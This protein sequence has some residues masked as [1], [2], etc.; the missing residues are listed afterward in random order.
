MDYVKIGKYIKEK[1]V[2]KGLTQEELGKLVYVSGKAVSKWERGL[3]IPDINILEKLAHELDTD[4]YD[5][6]QIKKKSDIDVDKLVKEEL[7][8]NNKK[9]RKRIILVIIVI[10]ILFLIVLFKLLPFG[11]K[12]AKVKYTHNTDKI[13]SLAKPMF[14]FDYKYNENNYSYKNLRY[15]YILKS[16]I[17]NYINTLEHISCNNTVYYYDK[18]SNVTII[19]YDVKGNLLY[20]TVSYA[21]KDGNYCELLKLDEYTNKLGIMSVEVGLR[22]KP[23][24]WSVYFSPRVNPEDLSDYVATFYIEY[25]GK[26]LEFS[27]GTY[28]I[29]GN[30]LIYTRKSFREKS[31]IID[32]P[33]VSTFIIGEDKELILKENYLSDYRESIIVGGH[34]EANDK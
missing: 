29:I 25:K 20:S 1:R 6:L 8:K 33:N 14:S 5:I 7:A 23:G 15:K 9:I 31:K 27:D 21:V 22:E 11:Y 19:N 18:N 17:K 16:E 26:V 4:L 24:D 3:S 30:E 10:A 34:Y 2:E 32:I 28:E 13:I 12:V